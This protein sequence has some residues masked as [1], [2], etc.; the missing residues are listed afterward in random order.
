MSWFQNLKIASKLF[1]AF[2]V[3]LLITTALGLFAI[4]QLGALNRATEVVTTNAIGSID[5]LSDMSTHLSN[6]RVA[7]LQHITASSPQEMAE[8][9]SDMDL[10]LKEIRRNRQDFE[11]LIVLE[12]ERRSINEFDALFKDFLIE[13]DKLLPIS[14]E[15]KN[16][17][18]HV[19]IRGR[20]RQLFEG[21]AATLESLRDVNEKE[22]FDAEVAA[23]ATYEEGRAWILSALGASVGVGFLLCLFLARLISRP[24]VEAVKV[25]DRIAEGD[26]TMRIEATGQDET[27]RLLNA[28]REMIRRLAQVIGEVREGAGT[29]TGAAAQVSVSSQSLS[30]GTSEQASSVEETTASL[31][32]MSATIDQT[33]QHSRQMEQ[34]ALKGAKEARESGEAVAQT[35]EAMGEIAEK[36]TIIEEIAYQTNLLALNAAIEAARGGEH[37]KGFAVVATEVRKLAERSQT[38]AKEISGLAGRSVRVAQ[39][40]GELLMELVPSIQKTTQLVQEVV[41]ASGEQASGVRQMSRAMVQVDQVTQRNASASEELASTAEELSAQAETLQ[42]LV[43]FFRVGQGDG[44]TPR[45]VPPRTPGTQ[46]PSGGGGGPQQALL[47]VT[48]ALK[49]ATQ[50]SLSVARELAAEDREFKRF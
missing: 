9:E 25:A 33:S 6:F 45:P 32:Q 7:E 8:F 49:N 38:A 50:G 35:V 34:M 30:Q 17:E 26:L 2:F 46:P 16:D 40:S 18:A 37:G 4:D 22:S 21:A 3:V 44:R 48:Q 42:H 39:R 5:H 10:A 23:R 12:V 1:C 29:L 27:G 14:R 41:A 28:M 47:S 20:S 36:I 24:L 19:F 11:P 13:H 31:E 15:N 43:S